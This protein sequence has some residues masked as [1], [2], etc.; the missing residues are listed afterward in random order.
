[1]FIQKQ[2]R[3]IPFLVNIDGESVQEIPDFDACME[4]DITHTHDSYMET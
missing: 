1:M 4:T 3:I 2:K